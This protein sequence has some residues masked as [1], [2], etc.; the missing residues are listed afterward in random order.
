MWLKMNSLHCRQAIGLRSRQQGQ[1]TVEMI[2]ISFFLV[3]LMIIAPLLAKYLDIAETATV[4][5]RYVAFE[6]AVHHT[7]SQ[8]GWK[9]DATLAKE[10][11]RRFFSNGDAPIKT[12]DVAGNFNAN[13]NVLWF[14]H[15]GDALLPDFDKNV[16]VTTKK[17]AL[18]QPFGA[19][20]AGAFNLSQDNL[21]TG[22]VNVNIA[23]IAGLAPFDVLGLSVDRHTTVLVD[24][25][26]ASGPDQVSSKVRGSG[27]AYPYQG[28]EVLATLMYPLISLFEFGAP[29]PVIGRVD[30]DWVPKDR[31]LQSYQ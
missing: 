19:L 1:S 4:A 30:P 6:G 27:T 7:S 22:R 15:R 13:R 26:A 11:Q 16:I 21:Y 20:Y 24:P 5:S 8:G 31:V 3:P 9:S 17:D 2:V 14:D 28:L 29:P 12:N 10:V 25:W 23:N 18:A